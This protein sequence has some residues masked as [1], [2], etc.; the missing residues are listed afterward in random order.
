[1][2]SHCNIQKKY[3][4]T[5]GWGLL[6]LMTTQQHLTIQTINYSMVDL[7][8]KSPIKVVITKIDVY[9]VLHAMMKS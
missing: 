5:L 8:T 9:V 7:S 4:K 6:A 2:L 1:M 3:P